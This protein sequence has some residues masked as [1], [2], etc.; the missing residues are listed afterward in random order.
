MAITFIF[1]ACI[2]TAALLAFWVGRIFFLLLKILIIAALVY[3]VFT[4]VEV[5]QWKD[6]MLEKVSPP[7]QLL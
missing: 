7:A 1:L 2:T 4:R 5:L 3:F 6:R